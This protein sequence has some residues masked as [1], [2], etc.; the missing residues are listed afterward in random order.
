V[1]S[2]AAPDVIEWAGESYT[3]QK[4]PGSQFVILSDDQSPGIQMADVVLW[5]YVQSIKGKELPPGCTKI[6]NLVLQRGW[7]NDFSFAG[8]E[9]S[10]M[11]KWGE[12]LFGPIDPGKLEAAQKMLD[13]AEKRRLQSIKQ[14]EI[15]GLAPFMRDSFP[16]P[17]T[18]S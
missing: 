18:P 14:Y 2:N 5:L 9:K 16:K 10:I 15:D 1:I 3:I 6:L 8:V 13:E 4:V 12:V 11:K 17:H 7:S